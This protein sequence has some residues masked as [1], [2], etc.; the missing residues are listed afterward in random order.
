MSMGLLLL[1]LLLPLAAALDTGKAYSPLIRGAAVHWIYF[2]GGGA[3]REKS[4]ENYSL[5]D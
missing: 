5:K 3:L 1:L 2:G 4:T